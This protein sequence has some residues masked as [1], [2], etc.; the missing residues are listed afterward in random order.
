MGPGTRSKGGAVGSCSVLTLRA[1]HSS[2]PP[3]DSLL[4]VRLESE[5]Q[6]WLDGLAAVHIM[7]RLLKVLHLRHETSVSITLHVP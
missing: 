5:G 7:Q 3:L 1:T 6:D 2:G 4:L